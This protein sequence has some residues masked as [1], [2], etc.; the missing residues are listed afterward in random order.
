MSGRAQAYLIGEREAEEQRDMQIA[1]K[2]PSHE[3]KED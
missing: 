3:I 2:P 1:L